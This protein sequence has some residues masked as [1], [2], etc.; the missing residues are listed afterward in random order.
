MGRIMDFA[1]VL[2]HRKAVRNYLPDAVPHET[3]ERIVTRGRKIPSAG[4]SQGLRLVVVTAEATRR[5]IADLAGEP[6]YVELGHEPWISRAPAHI[7]VGIRE[8]DYHE[9]YREPDKLTEDGA[10]IDWPVP[11]WYVD[12]GAAVM[13]LML[14]VVDEGLA[15]G[16]F[17]L[18]DW[19]ELRALL[20]MPGDVAP[21]AIL[22]VGKRAAETVQGSARR[23]WKPLDTVVHWER[24][25]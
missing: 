4:H 19:D 7:V 8:D 5:A 15:A 2:R 17:G 14:A 23:G 16:I 12:A 10:E 1:D 3:L 22:T 6:A 9:R 11:Y 21:V 18:H 20:G 24:W 13:L 25:V